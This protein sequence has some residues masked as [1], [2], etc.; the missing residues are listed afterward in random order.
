VAN[1]FYIISLTELIDSF[2]DDTL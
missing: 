1:E 2:G